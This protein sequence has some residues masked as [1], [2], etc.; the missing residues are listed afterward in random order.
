MQR[1]PRRQ[2]TPEFRAGAVKLVLEEG[3]SM[4]QV[5]KDLDL[6]RSA[7]ENWVRQ[8]RVDASRGT[9]EAL[10]TSEKD[11]LARLRRENHQLR[12]EREILKKLHRQ[13]WPELLFDA[14]EVGVRVGA[15]ASAHD[16]RD[17]P[18]FKLGA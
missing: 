18:R 4:A 16:A 1:R 13:I 6:T 9:A 7:L 17:A 15:E 2:Y 14:S 11:E 12:M 8:A 10:T 5:A 3:K